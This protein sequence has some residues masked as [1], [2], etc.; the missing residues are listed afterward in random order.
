LQTK[1]GIGA[2][3]LVRKTRFGNRPRSGGR[4]LPVIAAWMTLALANAD[5]Q[6]AQTLGQVK[7]VYVE[8]FGQDDVGGKL[9]ERLVE[10][11]R[12]RAKLE[13]VGAAGEADAVIKGNCSIWVTGYVS[14]D[15][16]SPS[17]TRRPVFTGFLSA[18]VVGKTGEPLWSYLVTPSKFRVGTVTDDLAD[19]LVKKLVDDLGHSSEAATAP[20]SGGARV[21][22]GLTAA[23]ATFPAPLYQKWFES[24]A[25]EHSDA[26]ITYN[27]VGSEEGIRLLLDSKVDFAGSDVPLADA[28][29]GEIQGGVLHFATVIGAVVPI[30][31]VKGLDRPLNFTPEAL[32]GIYQGKIRKWNDPVIRA[33]NHGV[34]LPDSEIAVVH[35]AD[36]SGT[37]FVWTDYLSKVSADWKSA[38]GAGSTVSWPTG[39]GAEGN[40]AVAAKV[41]K[42]PNAVGY[43]ELVYALRHELSYGTVRNAAGRFL[44]ADLASLTE[45]ASEAAAKMNGDFRVSITNAAGKDAYPIA[46][47]TWWLLPKGASGA[48]RAAEVELLQWMLTA[49]QKECS[50]LGYGPLPKVVA[51][52]ELEA[53]SALK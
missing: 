14:N 29:A 39:E 2:S 51:T 17:N 53:V 42:T 8:P 6:T 11:V 46:S 44:Q 37:T 1:P 24:F 18:E 21:E 7:K 45:A 50:A 33:A 9:R 40:D 34:A 10:D 32:A 16:R 28:K 52:R 36:G 19:H 4:W 25:E 31:N 47:F 49:G 15:P 5:A 22:A 43:V 27:A 38:V 23:G 20:A 48:K 30:Y 12:K 41:Q 26:H 13:V 3:H 35:R